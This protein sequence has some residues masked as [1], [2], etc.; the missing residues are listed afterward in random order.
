MNDLLTDQMFKAMYPK[1]TPKQRQLYLPY[2]NLAMAKFN[3]NT[4]RRIANFNAHLEHESSGLTK[5]FE[6]LKYSAKRLTEVWPNRFPTLAIAN[7]YAGQP[8]KLANKVYAGRLGN[9]KPGD[10]WKYRGQG[11]IQFTGKDVYAAFTKYCQDILGMDVDFV[12]HPEQICLPEFMFLAAAW[13]ICVYKKALKSLDNPDIAVSTK[14][15]NGGLNGLAERKQNFKENLRILPDDFKLMPYDEMFSQ[16]Q[17][18]GAFISDSTPHMENITV[19]TEHDNELVSN[20][21]L[22]VKIPDEVSPDNQ[23]NNTNQPSLKAEV[24]DGEI[25]LQANAG[26]PKP[27]EKIA[28]I[29][30]SSRL[31]FIWG[32]ITGMVT[33]NVTFSAFADYMGQVK[34]LGLSEAFWT[35]LI[36]FVIAGCLIAL[37]VIFIRWLIDKHQTLK[38]VEANSTPDNKATVAK[39]ED[40]DRL[41]ENGYKL[42]YQTA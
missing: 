10:G 19:D 29:E 8:E 40:I 3:I 28:V 24:K 4:E 31:K 37:I 11:P 30:K 16:L 13:F 14:I 36:W 21:E 23:E 42:I 15:I 1:L 33:G 26:T 18:D 17:K 12:A 6:D 32:K 39:P 20:D 7:Q 34:G 27:P 5:F 2:L 22:T 38:L 25:N 41:K 35:N 9:N